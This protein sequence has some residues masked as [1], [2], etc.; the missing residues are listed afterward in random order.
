MR[1][2]L[3]A[4][5]G[6][7]TGPW[8]PMV[9]LDGEVT[10]E[11]LEPGIDEVIVEVRPTNDTPYQESDT[12][13]VITFTCDGKVVIKPQEKALIRARRVRSS[14]KEIHLWVS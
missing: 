14:G 4:N 1:P 10:A 11:G 5:N 3:V 13:T 6:P 7:Y 12:D 8:V 2:L 9:G